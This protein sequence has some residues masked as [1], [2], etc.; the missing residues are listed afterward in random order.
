M[1]RRLVQMMLVGSLQL[2]APGFTEDGIYCTV[3][4]NV[5]NAK[6][7]LNDNGSYLFETKMTMH[8]SNDNDL[9]DP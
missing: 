8:S 4:G 9:T 5:S 6:N 1:L 2:R 3:R 7:N